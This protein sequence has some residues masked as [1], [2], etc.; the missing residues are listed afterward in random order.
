[1]TATFT[2]KGRITVRWSPPLEYHQNGFIDQYQ[3]RLIDP[4]HGG[5]LFVVVNSS[6]LQ[7]SFSLSSLSPGY[8]YTI[9]VS[10]HNSDGYGP[11]SLPVSIIMHDRYVAYASYYI[12]FYV[13]LFI[14]G[15]SGVAVAMDVYL[16][17]MVVIAGIL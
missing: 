6:S 11:Y 14:S 10:G 9:Q 3:I 8:S 13:I 1:M 12:P 5:N 16:V 15:S 4:E 2:T 7:Y 17:V